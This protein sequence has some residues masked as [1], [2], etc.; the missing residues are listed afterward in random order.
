MV[1]CT[2]QPVWYC[3]LHWVIVAHQE[4]ADNVMIFLDKIDT[5]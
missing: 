5:F 1:V 2:V 3:M 4:T